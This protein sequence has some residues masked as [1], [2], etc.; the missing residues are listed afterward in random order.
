MHPIV[1]AVTIAMLCATRA[2]PSAHM[3]TTSRLRI[4]NN[5]GLRAAQGHLRPW[6]G[7]G[8]PNRWLRF[9][10]S[11]FNRRPRLLAK[12]AGM[13]RHCRHYMGQL[14]AHINALSVSMDINGRK[15]LVH[16]DS[17]AV[18]WWPSM[19]S[20]TVPAWQRMGA[21]HRLRRHHATKSTLVHWRSLQAL[22]GVTLER[23]SP[24]QRINIWPFHCTA[25]DRP[26]RA[27]TVELIHHR[28]C[29][30]REQCGLP[31]GSS[32]PITWQ[33]L[34]LSATRAYPP[35]MS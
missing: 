24:T 20:H 26:R 19:S 34:Q 14:A 35:I 3:P 8:C 13:P 30:L 11:L 27:T 21:Q 6:R 12:Q 9:R 10:L 29:Q 18:R 22:H 7:E 1:A 2:S 32:R 33:H 25:A 16:T 17:I 4:G 5:R 28:N 15:F 31:R 23:R